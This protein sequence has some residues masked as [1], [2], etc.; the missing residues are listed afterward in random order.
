MS[1]EINKFGG[2]SVNSASAVQNMA[3][4]VEH[5]SHKPVVIV[6]SAMGKTTNNLELLV[7]RSGVLPSDWKDTLAKVR[8]YH[9]GIIHELFANGSTDVEQKVERLLHLLE[10][11]LQQPSFDYNYSY[12]QIVSIGELIST[13]IVSEYLNYKGIAN[14]WIDVRSIIKTDATYREGKVD[15]ELTQSCVNKILKPAVDDR[16]IVITQGFI[17]GAMQGSTTTLGREGSDYSAAI[18]AFCLGAKAMVIW[19]D[20]PGFLNADPK[21][22]SNTQ[23]INTIPY[24]EAIELAYYGASIIHPKTVKPLQNKEIP[25][26][27]KSFLTPQSEGSVIKTAN[28]ID[29]ET[30]LYIF[31]NNQVLLSIMP[32]DFSFIAE[33]N[34]QKIFGEFAEIG[35]KVN[36]IQNS[37]LSFSVCIDGHHLVFDKLIPSLQKDFH[38]RYNEGL[39]LITIRY[40]TPEII[41]EIVGNRKIYLEQ[42]SRITAQIIVDR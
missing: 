33:D 4:I 31:K 37:A 29:P 23:K 18:L 26:Y 15:W 25:L 22:F 14:K 17:A 11:Q 12:D 9:Y 20:V 27:V 1:Y 5:Y 21:F 30:P 24:N 3:H 2:A 6:V 19:K 8:D 28:H 34:L 39:Q 13:T 7:P 40:Y 10:E 32:K 41:T 16:G 42:H 38:V 35:I 36:M